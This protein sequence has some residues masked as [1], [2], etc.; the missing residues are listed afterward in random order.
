MGL[1]DKFLKKNSTSH[2]N[3]EEGKTL[4]EMGMAHALNFESNKAIE[5]YTESLSKSPNPAPLQNRANLLAKR[6]DFEAALRDLELARKLDLMQGKQFQ[7]AIQEESLKIEIYTS[8]IKNR[9][10]FT[11]SLQENG[12]KFVAHRL[13]QVS[14]EVTEKALMYATTKQVAL[15]YFFFNE[16]DNI[17]KFDDITRFPSM[18]WELHAYPNDFIQEKISNTPPDYF[19][20]EAKMYTLLCAHSDGDRYPLRDA[21]M[22]YAHEYLMNY[23]YQGSQHGL[24]SDSRGVIKEAHAFLPD[25][26]EY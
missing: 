5:L 23:D 22:Y 15:E 20:S 17:K 18:E 8:A 2:N 14:F 12:L 24:D 10:H 1:F 3:H 21:V 13:I 9:D 25:D 26:F 16:L 11:T 7:S 19:Q 6:L 4:F